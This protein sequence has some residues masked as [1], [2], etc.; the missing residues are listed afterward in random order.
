MYFEK[1]R[2]NNQYLVFATYHGFDLG[3]D[4]SVQNEKYDQWEKY[5]DFYDLV[6][7]YYRFYDLV[8]DYYRDNKE[9]KVYVKGGE[10]DSESDGEGNQYILML[11]M[12][13]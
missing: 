7:D 4:L 9:V 2:G 13:I 10:Y 5:E 11:L 6:Q 8:Q 12:H 3:K 1:K